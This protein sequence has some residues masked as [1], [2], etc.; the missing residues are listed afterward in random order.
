MGGIPG[1]CAGCGD[2][3]CS[4]CFGT[5]IDIET[6]GG[7]GNA[8]DCLT[9]GIVDGRV[10]ARL[11]DESGAGGALANGD[12]VVVCAGGTTELSVYADTCSQIQAIAAPAAG[13]GGDLVAGDVVLVDSGALCIKKRVTANDCPPAAVPALGACVTADLEPVFCDPAS[14]T[15]RTRPRSVTRTA[16]LV[17]PNPAALNLLF[18]AQGVQN[19]QA[20]GFVMFTSATATIAN[21]SCTY[22]LLTMLVAQPGYLEFIGPEN[23]WFQLIIEESV[24]GG[25][26]APIHTPLTDYRLAFGG[27]IAD[28]RAI[29]GWTRTYNVPAAGAL[30]YAYRI[31]VVRLHPNVPNINCTVQ[32]IGGRVTLIGGSQ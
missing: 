12:S 7:T 25:A 16:D 13:V 31:T 22:P 9:L 17:V 30:T 18:L 21:P 2:P 1:P 23:P 10:S 5:S 8:G 6:L 24:N 15:L 11:C 4:C 29:P 32:T 26:F 14:A 3:A 27:D 19:N 28:S 20:T